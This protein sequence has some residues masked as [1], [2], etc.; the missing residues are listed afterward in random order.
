MFFGKP[1]EKQKNICREKLLIDTLVLSDKQ[2]EKY[3]DILEK[4]E[5]EHELTKDDYIRICKEKQA[6]SSSEF[7]YSHYGFSSEI[8]L[9][10]PQ[11]VFFSVP[12]SNGWTAEVNG[13]KADVEK[14]SYGFMAVRA[15]TGTN[16]IVFRYRTPGLT[17][18]TIV[19]IVGILLLTGYLIINRIF[20]KNDYGNRHTHFYCYDSFSEPAASRKYC[21]NLLGK[22]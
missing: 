7:R 2:I 12:Y 21:E 15:D 3:S 19:T 18:G 1:S 11:L 16:E 9:D 8:T 14:V 17:S 20:F 22:D 13:K 10:K 5:P 4:Y 6:N